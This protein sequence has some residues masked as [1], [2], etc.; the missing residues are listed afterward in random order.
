M[1]TTYSRD[2]TIYRR[3][4]IITEHSSSG[5]KH[6]AYVR[7]IV[8]MITHSL[9]LLY[10]FLHSLGPKDSDITVRDRYITYKYITNRTS[11]SDEPSKQSRNR[12]TQNEDTTQ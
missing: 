3:F 7:G 4:K 1:K 9:P 11:H 2:Y 8:V 12:E 10:R 6:T 5:Y